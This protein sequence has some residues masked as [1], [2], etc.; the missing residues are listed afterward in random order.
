VKEEKKATKATQGDRN[1]FWAAFE[2][3]TNI[4]ARN[5]E[6]QPKELNILENS[7]AKLDEESQRRL[8]FL[9][10]KRVLEGDAK[11]QS[12][13]V[14]ARIAKM[15]AVAYNTSA[16]KKLLDNGLMLSDLISVGLAEIR[17]KDNGRPFIVYFLGK[18]ALQKA[19]KELRTHGKIGPAM[20]IEDHLRRGERYKLLAEAAH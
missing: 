9:L 4:Q 8:V 2:A 15:I 12:L 6:D 16:V 13:F 14:T 17:K 1:P 3:A 18:E 20:I 19:S 5:P 10:S 11:I 7:F